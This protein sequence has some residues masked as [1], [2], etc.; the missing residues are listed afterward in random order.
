MP[1][2]SSR[3]E[4]AKE[5]QRAV[6]DQ[7]LL[8]T[9]ISEATF[10]EW[11]S[12]HQID[13]NNYTFVYNLENSLPEGLLEGLYNNRRQLVSMRLSEINPDNESE[14]LQTVMPNLDRVHLS[15]VHRNE[16]KETYTFSFV[17]PCE[18]NGSRADGSVRIYKKLFFCHCVFF[19]NSNDVK[20]IFNP[21]TNLL[22]VNGVK[23]KKRSD[24]SPIA[25][26]FFNKIKEIININELH[27]KSPTWIPQSLYQLAEDA[28]SHKNPEITEKAF[29][30]QESIESFAMGLL[31]EAGID[32]DNEQAYVN[33]FI[34]DIQFSFEAQL[35]EKMGFNEEEDTI[36]IFKQRSD[37]VTHII[38]VESTEEGFKSGLAAQ[39]ARRSRQD[40]DIDL[41]GVI[42]KTNERIYKFLVE[43]GTD[44]YLIRSTNTFVEEEVVNIVIRKLNE[45]REQIQAAAADYSSDSEGT[46]S[47]QA[48]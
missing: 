11:L 38:S 43:Q 41:L 40:G 22:N 3:D 29:N 2:K 18:V 48:E 19:D 17:A 39:A 45:Y 10:S 1:K 36:T 25:D 12:L 42:L 7:G 27:I 46:I 24:W 13:G 5:L 37:G 9:V 30:A 4:M 20:I 15:G 6:T 23:K 47:T 32:T 14:D 28:T 35:I 31:K 44:A 33:K 21:T 26:L 8:G 34:Q 16:A